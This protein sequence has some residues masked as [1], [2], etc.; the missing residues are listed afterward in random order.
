MHEL[1]HRGGKAAI[2]GIN[3]TDVK[4]LKLSV[5]SVNVLNKFEEITKPLVGTIL[6]NAKSIQ[7]LANLR[8]TLLPRLI[9]GQLQLPE[10]GQLEESLP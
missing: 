4:E 10:V 6:N 7:S 9:S 3:Q 2:P 1:K 8:D 5:P